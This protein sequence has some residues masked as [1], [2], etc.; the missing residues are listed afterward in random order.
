MQLY[1][2]GKLLIDNWTK[3]RR[4]NAF[5]GVATLEAK[6]VVHIPAG[7]S[8]AI[9]VDFVNVRGPAPEDGDLDEIIMD[10]GAGLR[11]GGAEV[12]QGGADAELERAV[13]LAKGSDVAIVVVGLN[14]D[15]ETEGYDR[16][17]LDLP[18]KTNELVK[19]VAE[20]NK[21]TVVVTQSVS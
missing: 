15:W 2:D 6:G 11:V 5:F 21:N 8:P 14:S 18:G 4:G 13:Q 3:Q 1:V 10:S 16:K 17:T 20:A 9:H 7:H 12:L 19:R